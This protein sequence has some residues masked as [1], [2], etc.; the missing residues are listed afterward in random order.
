MMSASEIPRLIISVGIL[1]LFGAAY[2]LHPDNAL[3]VGS[4][5]SMASTASSYWLGSSK[6]STDKDAS[7]GKAL[8]LAKANT[9]EQKPDVMLKPG[10]TARAEGE[11]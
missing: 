6:G 7:T 10:E 4:L 2:I 9:P 3:L 1:L 11:N 5:I 8:D